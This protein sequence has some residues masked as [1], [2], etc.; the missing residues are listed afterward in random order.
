MYKA[1][2]L[3]RVRRSL[4]SLAAGFL[5]AILA[6]GQVEAGT[7]TV[8][9]GWDASVS[10]DVLDYKV[11]YGIVSGDYTNVISSGGDTNVTISGLVLGN[12]YFFAATAV[13]M[14]GQESIY[15][16]ETNYDTRTGPADTAPVVSVIADQVTD[17]DTPTAPIA[18]TISDAETPAASLIVS[19]TSSDQALVP[20]ENMAF[21]GGDGNR[22]LVI[23]PAAGLSGSAIITISVGDGTLV[24]SRS[25]TLTVRSTASYVAA[26]S[27]YNGLFYESNQVA[28]DSAGA[29]KLTTTTTMAYSGAVRHRGHYYP[30]SGQLNTFGQ[31]S[32]V[33][34]RFGKTPLLLAFDC[35]I[36]SQTA[37]VVGTLS[38]ETWQASLIG[39]RALYNAATNPAPWAGSYTMVLP[40]QTTDPNSPQGHSSGYA[41]ISKGGLAYVAAS[42]ADGSYIT[43]SAPIS[44][45][46]AWPFYVTPYLNGGLLLAWFNLNSQPGTNLDLG[47]LTS[48]IKL[49]DGN[50]RYFNSGFTNESK[51]VGSI[52]IKPAGSQD[53]IVN[54]NHAQLKFSNGNNPAS[55]SNNIGFGQYNSVTN[56][57]INRLSLTFTLN[58]GVFNGWVAD[59]NNG[60]YLYF[61]GAVLQKLDAGFGMVLGT[62]QSS[63]VELLGQ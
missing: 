12:V 57:S 41:R 16:V 60:Q 49:P 7:N 34:K 42:L 29:F 45:D 47:G 39:D 59:P 25:F 6:A 24:T 9:L 27:S 4:P 50:G 48:W 31:G 2:P 32:N 62:D 23:T 61:K 35:G 43:Q 1:G 38:D 26:A 56:E 3:D 53:H 5:F 20:K 46:G 51:M 40:G 54:A 52:Y 13:D 36:S 28:V 19:G 11:Y 10:P 18:F 44:R 63:Q 37:Q 22:N 15:S 8:T 14:L 30:F 55:F 17:Q 58:T 33:I 21:G